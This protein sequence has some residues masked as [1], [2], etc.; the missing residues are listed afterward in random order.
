MNPCSSR[1]AGSRRFLPRLLPPQSQPL[2]P[3]AALVPAEK[4]TGAESSQGRW[5]PPPHRG[6]LTG[7]APR[8]AAPAREN[9]LAG[10]AATPILGAQSCERLKLLRSPRVNRKPQQVTEIKGQKPEEPSQEPG[11]GRPAP[12]GRQPGLRAGSPLPTLPA[13]SPSPRTVSGPP[14][15][16]PWPGPPACGGEGGHPART[17]ERGTWQPGATGLPQGLALGA[18]TP[19]VSEG[20]SGEKAPRTVKR[21]SAP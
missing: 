4:E 13:G 8:E 16:L 17:Q 11:R 21:G 12:G 7:M 3:T 20:L 14:R 15:A 6:D 1:Q 18:F 19:Q 2:T 5:P 10:H 9:R